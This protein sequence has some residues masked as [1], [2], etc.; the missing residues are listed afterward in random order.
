ME[1]NKCKTD[2][3]VQAR[4]NTELIRKVHSLETKLS[5]MKNMSPKRFTPKPTKIQEQ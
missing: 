2:I 5:L 3:E 1:L 4:V